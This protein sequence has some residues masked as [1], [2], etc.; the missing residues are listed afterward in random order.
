MI[1]GH[2]LGAWC[3]SP[4]DSDSE[5]EYLSPSDH[6]IRGTGQA[7]GSPETPFQS[8]LYLPSAPQRT[9]ETEAHHHAKP[10]ISYSTSVTV[11]LTGPRSARPRGPAAPG[12]AAPGAGPESR[13]SH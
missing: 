9:R 6:Q 1:I 7:R 12:R 5:S 3:E 8:F 11:T 13:G 4:S 10:H 2:S